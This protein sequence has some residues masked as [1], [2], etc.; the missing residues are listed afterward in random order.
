MIS[1]INFLIFII[2]V[3]GIC[4]MVYGFCNDSTIC[5]SLGGFLFGV[6]ISSLVEI[7]I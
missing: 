2:I 3:V 6:G 7:N 1:I 5:A 4:V